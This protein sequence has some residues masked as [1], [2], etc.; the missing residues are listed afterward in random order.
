MTN[1]LWMDIQAQPENLRNVVDHLY[2]KERSRLQTAAD[3]LIG[4]QPIVLIGM[5]S[6]EY[7]CHPAHIALSRAGRLSQ[8]MGASDALYTHLPALKNARVV[9][10][11][12]SGETVEIVKLGQALAE[13]GIPFLAVTNEKDSRLARLATHIL[14]TNSR[15][16]DLVSI[17]I[18]TSM[19]AAML[20]LV[21][22]A[23]GQQTAFREAAEETATALGKSTAHAW[24]ISDSAANLL[25]DAR[26]IY[27]LYR[28][29]SIAS[30]LCGRLV[31]EEV[32]RTPAVAMEAG[33]FRQGPIEVMDERFRGVIFLPSGEVGQLNHALAGDI[34]STGA[35][36]LAVGE[37]TGLPSRSNFLSFE[38]P[39]PVDLFRPILELN[40][41]QTLAYTLAERQ[42]ISPGNV[43]YISKVIRTETGMPKDQP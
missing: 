33:V 8:V 42:G 23:V 1:A 22:E 7:L 19:L 31:L 41:L 17:N 6:A 10:N 14:W 32:A 15:K 40:P 28:G 2:G 38:T 21:G 12:R 35:R 13:A 25:G 36:L 16:D 11:S 37:P 43:R 27:L 39:A 26:P 34:L 30:A 20:I 29:A 18:I 3:F 24:D 5:A 4:D 9:I